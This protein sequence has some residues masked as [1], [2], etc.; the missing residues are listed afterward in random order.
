[1]ASSTATSTS[2]VI[3]TLV[4]NL[5]LFGVFIACF[6][7]LR[8]RFKRIYS[9]KSSFDLVPE[10][11][12]PEPLP[13]DPFRWIF[14]LLTKP[15]SFII[16]QAGLDGYF[17]LRYLLVL[18]CVFLGG[19]ATYAVLLPINAVRGNNNTGFDQLSISNVSDSGRYYAHVFIGWVFYGTVVFVIYR[20]LFFFNSLRSAVLSSPKYAKS[21]ESRTV[22]FQCVPDIL[23]DEKQFFKLFN[24]V[25]RIYVTRTWRKLSNKVRQRQA[26]A[27]KLETAQNKLLKNAVKAKLK[28]DKNNTVIEP[29]NDI[30]S[31][32]P[33]SKRPRH[34]PDGM[35]SKKVDTIEYCLAK[36]KELDVEVTAM[37]KKY[38]SAKPK[39]SVFVEF[40]DQ[41]H[42]QVA[43]QSVIHHNPLRMSPAYTGLAPAD[44]KW[45]NLRIFWWEKMSRRFIAASIICVVIILW[46][47]PVAFVGVISNLTY[48]TNLKAFHWLRFIYN[49]PKAL[50]GLI[51]GLLPTIL[52]SLLM[53]ILPMF[54]R[55][56]AQVAGAPS[57]QQV[58]LFTQNAYFGFLI[59][60]VFLV[61]TISSSATST[62]TQI[63]EEPQKA[64][65]ILAQG[66]PRASNFF[67]SYLILQG[68]SI[69]GGSLFQVVGL[70]LYYILGYILDGTVRKKWARFSGLGTVA[71]GTTFPIY[72]NL[73]CIALAYSVISPLILIFATV[74]F[75]LVYIAF[76][77]N[78]TYCFIEA[79]DSRGMHYPRALFQTFTGIYLGQICMLGIFVVGKGWGPI[80]LQIIGMFVTVFS[81]I[82]MNAAFDHLLKVMP[83]DCMK[84]MDGVSKTASF[85]GTSE[86]QAKVLD[87]KRKSKSVKQLRRLENELHEEKMAQK[88]VKEE[89]LNEENDESYEEDHQIV[90]LL[91][92]RDNKTTEST[93]PLVRFIRPDVYLN[94][95]HVKTMLPA[96]Y[97]IEPSLDDDRHAYD[98]PVISAKLPTLWIPK[99]PMGLSTIE[100]EKMSS[101]I[102]ASD[103]NASFDAKGRI[104]C[105]GPPE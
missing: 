49:M 82:H 58:E 48:L 84:A 53:L 86:Y 27:T 33:E 73:A 4:A 69:A 68:L 54:I 62:V 46:A 92:D 28:A 34:R 96:Q 37:Q 88:Q 98:E 51:T 21:L 100:I 29:A 57:V 72:T 30:N 13:K 38:R 55:G 70:F 25:K 36:I 81:H 56:M 7:I 47:I 17:F 20:E 43:Y 45:S 26:L 44:I 40:E 41:Y 8:L 3:S 91:A 71:W 52:L 75:I 77:H 95:R 103:D 94:Y 61:T 104:I 85:E 87:R 66:L 16:Q 93:N 64:L 89:L 2:A 102:K 78:I 22:L 19:I 31:Y 76:S 90:P 50:L 99:D 6:L 10:E 59:V 32:V 79:P 9:P 101:V 23:L 11:K 14:I 42:A 83:I 74:A 60:N 24:G 1:M 5:I 35:F 15:H 105:L 63:I 39:N 18:A 97:N 12:K 65:N 67:I 80:V